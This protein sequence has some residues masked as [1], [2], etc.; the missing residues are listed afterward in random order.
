MVPVKKKPKKQ[1]SVARVRTREPPKQGPVARV[2]PKEQPKEPER[3]AAWRKLGEMLEEVLE[4]GPRGAARWHDFSELRE[5]GEK[6]RQQ[7]EAEKRADK[8]IKGVTPRQA[9][10]EELLSSLV[11]RKTTRN[12]R[13]LHSSVTT[14][15]LDASKQ[16]AVDMNARPKD[17][18]RRQKFR[19][20]IDEW[21]VA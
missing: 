4:K 5:L 19:K 12:E 3:K 9:E 17:P 14:E 1:G 13:G 2:S 7:R 20:A 15:D 11:F 6:S 18:R 16:L 8:G 10:R 21:G